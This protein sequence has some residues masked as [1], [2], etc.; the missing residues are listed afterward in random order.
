VLLALLAH[1]IETVA[2]PSLFSW[3]PGFGPNGLVGQVDAIA[4]VGGEVHAVGRM[5]D[6]TE[7]VHRW[8][9]QNWELVPGLWGAINS[10]VT[11]Q[12]MLVAGG[13]LV[14]SG[15]PLG[16]G[17]ALRSGAT[18][19][20]LG[21]TFDDTV[22]V[23]F[24]HDGMLVAGGG[25]T[26]VDGVSASR[27]A[28]WDG[29][30]WTPLGAGLRGIF[31]NRPAAVLSMCTYAGD[32]IAGG[33]FERSGSTVVEYIARWD[34]VAWNPLGSGMDSWVRALDVQGADLVAGGSFERA[35][36]V[37]APFVASWDGQSWTPMGQE[38]VFEVKDLELHGGD[39][40]A[41]GRF[42]LVAGT[43]AVARWD[44]TSW[45]ALDPSLGTL[46]WVLKVTSHGTSL[47]LGG[48]FEV[49]QPPFVD[50]ICLWDGV[51]LRSLG[52]G[53]GVAGGNLT[54]IYRL[55]P[56]HRGLVAAGS[57]ARA[58]STPGT[59]RIASWTGEQWN[60]IPGELGSSG[61][62]AILEFQDELF[63]GGHVGTPSIPLR[64]GNILKL[65]GASWQRIG[66]ASG[67][68]TALFAYEDAL[69]AAGSFSSIDGTSLNA[70]GRWTG[71]SW[72]TVGDELQIP[73]FDNIDEMNTSAG[74]LVVGGE[75]SPGSGFANVARLNGPH[76]EPMGQGFDHPVQSL[77]TH[78]DELFAGLASGVFRWDGAQWI[79][80]GNLTGGGARTLA[81]YD[82]SL[83]VGGSIL[84]IDGIQV[85][86][87]AR[88]KEGSWTPLGLGLD[89]TVWALAAFEGGLYAG[90]RFMAA[91]TRHSLSIAQWAP[92]SEVGTAAPLGYATAPSDV[93]VH[94]NPFR[95]RCWIVFDQP[96]PSAATVEVFDVMGRRV[97]A[98]TGA[99]EAGA[100]STSVWDAADGAGRRVAAGVYFLR[101]S[102]VSHERT[103]RVTVLR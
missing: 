71:G 98:L 34:G 86:H 66:E 85:N 8:N 68:V 20:P 72:E 22:N 6:G 94:P 28:R 69:I 76:W 16:N 88:W 82:G 96:S 27:V 33:N 2:Q 4:V 41:A 102:S 99:R 75:S 91:G 25:F 62:F 78:Q 19:L 42:E 37:V 46:P 52:S 93:S 45:T 65:T 7:A 90:G 14:I 74:H 92:D 18:W 23:L 67:S 50:N 3:Q 47:I 60:A 36:S 55:V 48:S 101:I 73:F 49:A 83:F 24:D 44:G 51:E 12:G 61:L 97:R 21:G 84:Q 63:V 95:D 59:S 32:L 5:P 80:E 31:V 29:T 57:F 1:P 54:S 30:S 100:R 11:F 81:S 89:N 87:V 40:I 43:H 70:I 77:H 9:G 38:A 10:L 35:G 15:N 56:T 13:Q 26:S 103:Q 17:V 79:V 53:Q 64:F 58:G 39:L